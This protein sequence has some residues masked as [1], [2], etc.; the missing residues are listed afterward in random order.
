MGSVSWYWFGPRAV[1]CP[2]LDQVFS[3]HLFFGLD[4]AAEAEAK[5]SPC[6]RVLATLPSHV[7]VAFH[8]SGLTFLIK[9]LHLHSSHPNFLMSAVLSV[10]YWVSWKSKWK[11]AKSIDVLGHSICLICPKENAHINTL[12]KLKN[13]QES[14]ARE[15]AL[16]S[17]E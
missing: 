11:V 10:I 14:A 15:Q 8:A 16:V 6:R 1:H 12:P 5:L 7:T 13:I 2:G 9:I 3:P 17:T 4:F